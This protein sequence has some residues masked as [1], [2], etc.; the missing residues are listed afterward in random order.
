MVVALRQPQ[1]PAAASLTIVPRD[2]LHPGS[3]DAYASEGRLLV[4]AWYVM[5][6]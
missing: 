3:W 2:S 5:L 6:G 4:P 1:R